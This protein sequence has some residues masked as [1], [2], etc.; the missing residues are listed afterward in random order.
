MAYTELK[1]RRSGR[2]A[3]LLSVR[4]NLILA[5]NL[6]NRELY[7]PDKL[8]NANA[9]W[10]AEDDIMHA[11]TYTRKFLRKHLDD[12]QPQFFIEAKRT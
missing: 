9:I 7:G 11:L 4:N 8:I 5:L 10:I 2:N 1:I 6:V 12:Y 3:M